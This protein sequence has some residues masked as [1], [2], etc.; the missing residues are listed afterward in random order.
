MSVEKALPHSKKRYDLVVYDTEGTPQ[1]LVECKAPSVAITEKTL[2]QVAS[3]ISLLDVPYILISNGYNHYFIQRYLDG[4]QIVQE[5][6][7]FTKISG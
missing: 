1:V 2:N 6:P 4:L 7:H 3:Y 5:F